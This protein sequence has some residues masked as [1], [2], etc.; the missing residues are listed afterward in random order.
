MAVSK[1]STVLTE[2]SAKFVANN[3]VIETPGDPN[4]SYLHKLV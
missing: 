4:C 3:F 1:K 2:G